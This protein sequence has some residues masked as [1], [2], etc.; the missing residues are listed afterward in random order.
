MDELAYESRV[1][2]A[3]QAIPSSRKL[4][5]KAQANEYVFMRMV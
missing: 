1:S 5:S 3:V 2:P 4:I